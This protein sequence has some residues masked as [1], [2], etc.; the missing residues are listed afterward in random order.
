MQFVFDMSSTYWDELATNIDLF[1]VSFNIAEHLSFK[2]LLLLRFDHRN[3]FMV[4][5]LLLI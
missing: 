4:S 1:P 5:H 3:I 2:Y